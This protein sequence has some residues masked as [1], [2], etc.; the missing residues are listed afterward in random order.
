MREPLVLRLNVEPTDPFW[1]VVRRVEVD[2]VL[3]TGWCPF[4]ASMSTAIP[5][6]LEGM[7]GVWFFLSQSWWDWMGRAGVKFTKQGGAG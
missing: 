7:P 5:D 4:V 2:L 6:R 3:T 1:T